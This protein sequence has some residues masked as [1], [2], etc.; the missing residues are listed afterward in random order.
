MKQ[1]WRDQIPEF[2]A[3]A[4]EQ[5]DIETESMFQLTELDDE[6]IVSMLQEVVEKAEASHQLMV[7]AYAIR[8]L[9]EAYALEAINILDDPEKLEELKKLAREFE[10]EDDNPNWN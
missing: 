5:V 1:H 7:L 8:H 6:K 4:R 2:V 9:L 3:K 10:A